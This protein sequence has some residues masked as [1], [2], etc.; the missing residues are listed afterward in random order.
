[1]NYQ[2]EMEKIINSLDYKP[3]LLLHVC[4]APCSSY[5]LSILS[6]YFDIDIIYYNPN[7]NTKEEYCKRLD[8]L[9]RLLNI[10]EYESKINII[11]CNYNNRDFFNAVKGL[12]KEVEGGKRCYECYKLRL[13]FIA[14]KAKKLG[15]EYFTTSLSISPYKNAC[16]LNEIGINLE[17]K[18]GVKYLV[19]DFKK[20]NGYKISIELSKKYNLYRQ[21]Y[22]GCIYSKIERR[23]KYEI[24]NKKNKEFE[25]SKIN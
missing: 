1:M 15:Y 23:K 14:Q 20:K 18:Y 5:V 6:K 8:E 11:D 19:A 22:C 21:D 4:C 24:R 17:K 10:V 9:K 7:I 3:R 2:V 13:D 12:E 25:E 16:W